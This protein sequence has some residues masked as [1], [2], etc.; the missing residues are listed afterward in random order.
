MNERLLC[1]IILWKLV[2]WWLLNEWK[3]TLLDYLMET[4]ERL[5]CLIFLHIYFDSGSNILQCKF[6]FFAFS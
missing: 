3:I 4:N 5:L 2:K 6:L 1:L